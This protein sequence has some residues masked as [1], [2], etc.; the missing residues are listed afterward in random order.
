M[1]GKKTV[2]VKFNVFCREVLRIELE[3]EPVIPR[4]E[5]DRL[6]VV[7]AIIDMVEMFPFEID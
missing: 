1:I 6:F 4:F 7:A 2:G 3:E 5:K